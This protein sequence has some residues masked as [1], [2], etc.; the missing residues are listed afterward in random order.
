[1]S[2]AV[3]EARDVDSD[4]EAWLAEH[5]ASDDRLI[6][7]LRERL[8]LATGLVALPCQHDGCFAVA[9][10]PIWMLGVAQKH[11]DRAEFR[12][13]LRAL[14]RCKDHRHD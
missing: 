2:V 13:H 14:A 5:A 1:M 7:W 12:D 10:Y 3:I 11:F 6:A 9:E 4:A 8:E